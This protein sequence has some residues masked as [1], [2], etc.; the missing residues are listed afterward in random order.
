LPSGNCSGTIIDAGY[1]ISD[2]NTCGFSATG[3]HNNIN[4]RLDPAGLY[5]NGGPTQTIALLAGSP[6][7]DAIPLYWCT[8]Q[9]TA[10]QRGFPRPDKGEKVCNIGAYE[11]HK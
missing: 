3:S 6:A 8:D 7:I 5:N 2:D 4:P 9:L 1:N 10:D 11:S